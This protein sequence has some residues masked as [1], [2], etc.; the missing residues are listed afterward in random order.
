[1]LSLFL[2]HSAS[3]A[4]FPLWI[5]PEVKKS[6]SFKF[7]ISYELAEPFKVIKS[8]FRWDLFCGESGRLRYFKNPSLLA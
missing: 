4:V 7:E 3:L 5:G 2:I 6:G 8:H 1:M